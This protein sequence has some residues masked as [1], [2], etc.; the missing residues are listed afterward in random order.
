MK[1]GG[2]DYNGF[3]KYDYNESI[4]RQILFYIKAAKISDGIDVGCG[5]GIYVMKFRDYGIPMMGC[6]ANPHTEELSKLILH[7][8]DTP[9][10]TLDITDEIEC[11][12]FFDLVLC[13]DV[14]SYIPSELLSKA[15]KNLTKLSRKSIIISLKKGE[16]S[17]LTQAICY[18]EDY[19]FRHNRTFSN[20]LSIGENTNYIFGVMEII[21]DKDINE[22]V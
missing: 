17:L 11:E 18:F 13:M 15:M 12:D 7:S 10:Q 5:V 19:G 21:N 2:W 9:C 1:N 20:L 6:D 4:F 22:H 3:L 16:E 8:N 14:L